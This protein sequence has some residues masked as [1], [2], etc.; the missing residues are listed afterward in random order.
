[1]KSRLAWLGEYGHA[2]LVR[3]GLRGIEK[4]CLRIDSDGRLSRKPHPQ[5]LGA[6]LT[7][8]HITTDYSEALLEFVTP[9]CATN[10]ETL[11]F[12]CDIHCFVA[13]NLDDELLW[14]QSMPCVV[15]PDEDV[16]I[17]YY[18]ESNL[19]RMK[20]IY[21]RGLGHRYGRAMQ[22][23]AGVHFNYSLPVGFW[24]A[25]QD[26]EESRQ[27]ESA[28]ISG[29]YL[30]MARNY[31]RNAWALIYLFGASPAVCKSFPLRAGH[32]L[33]ELDPHTWY[34][35]YGTSLRMSDIG[36]RN[37]S[38]ARLQISLNSLAE[39]VGGLTTAV[40][41]SSPEYERIGVNVDGEYR[42]L[43]ANM[44][45]IENEYYAAVRP[46]PK[47]KS[48]SR[49]TVAL[50]RSGVEYL[51]IRTL[52]LN[53]ADPVGVN[54]TQLRFVE[55]LLLYCLFT[56]SPPIGAAEQAEIDQR[57][58]LVAREGRKPGLEFSV[59]GADVPL[60]RLGLDLL[61]GIA[62]FA[63]L[64]DA[65]EEGYVDALEQQRSAIREP[66]LTPSARLL[67]DMTTRGQSYLDFMLEVSRA[68]G[69][70]FRS[71]ALTEERTSQLGELARVSIEEARALE[72]DTQ[73]SLEA[74]LAAYL[75]EV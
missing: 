45:Q 10:W 44:L 60:S 30:R 46:K 70:Y 64:L 35:P 39:Y 33:E 9:P 4:E 53:V 65:A 36:Y 17:A 2:A 51:E 38:Q 21:R 34:L 1:M 49:P 37:K 47:A 69:A 57:E 54:Q 73:E 74:Y 71:L 32:G 62:P 29:Q 68:H 14:A 56:D 20:T 16:P 58:L 48:S 59:D 43:N 27:D 67:A 41:S 55:A 26:Y 52:D 28:F 50:R 42:Q 15:G 72:N 11:Q 61:D 22:A 6:A 13:Q 12:L 23:I 66:E 63:A 19:G 75:A 31:R 5:A 8:P 7:H 3:H 18:G 24:A 40:T 25:Y